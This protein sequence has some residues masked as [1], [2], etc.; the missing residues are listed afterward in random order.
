[1][2]SELKLCPFCKAGETSIT[3]N[4]NWTGMRYVTYSYLLRHI[5]AERGII[6]FTRN[7]EAEVIAVWNR[8][9]EAQHEE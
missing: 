4:Q 6:Q 8:D 7:T 5:C 9:S 2:A 3:P 1:M